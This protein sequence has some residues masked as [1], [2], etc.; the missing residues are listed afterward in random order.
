MVTFIRSRRRVEQRLR[1]LFAFDDFTVVVETASFADVVRTL[2]FAA[3]GTF[4]IG[5][6]AEGVVSA[7]HVALRF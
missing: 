5:G 4:L 3:V 7:A 6:T 2:Q 1:S